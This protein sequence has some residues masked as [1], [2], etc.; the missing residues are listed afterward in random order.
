[1]TIDHTFIEPEYQGQKLV[2]KHVFSGVKLAIQEG[3]KLF[4]CFLTL[5]KKMQKNLS[6]KIFF[7]SKKLR[8]IVEFLKKNRKNEKSLFCQLR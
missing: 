5:R 7:T 1:M 8:I 2:E 3:K 6:I 4:H